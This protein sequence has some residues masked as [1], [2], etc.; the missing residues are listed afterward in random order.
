MNKTKSKVK[1]DAAVK[2]LVA[3][4]NKKVDERYKLPEF[5]LVKL[6]DYLQGLVDE[7][8]NGIVQF[9]I[10][11][12]CGAGG[13]SEG[14]EKSVFLS[15]KCSAII[16]GIN[17]DKKAIYSQAI[18]H[19]L[20]Y[21]T[22]EDIR[23]AHLEPI[24]NLL[25]ILRARFPQCPIILW[26]SLECTNHSNAKG[27]MSRDPDSR[28]LPWELYRY[29]EALNPDGIWI[30]NVKEFAEWGPMM[31]KVQ[32]LKGSKKV[33]LKNPIPEHLSDK[34]YEEKI[35]TGWICSCPLEKVTEGKGKNKK[36]VALIPAWRVIDELKG[37]YFMPWVDK[38]NSYGYHMDRRIL[39]AADYGVP[40][41]RKRLFIIFMRKG[42]PIQ[43]PHPTHSKNPKPGD[44]FDGLKK[45][46][47]VKECLDFEVEGRSVFEPGHVQSDKTWERIY[48]GLIKFI[49]GGKKNFEVQDT[50][51]IMKYMGNNQKTGINVGASINNPSNAITVQGRLA[52]VN[53]LLFDKHWIA[54]YNSSHNNTK[55]NAGQ[56]IDQ[57]SP[58]ITTISGSALMNA[59]FLDV[60]YGKG[61]PSSVETPSPTV[62][63]K[64]GLSIVDV[65]FM[66]NYQGQSTANSVDETSPTIMTKEKLALIGVKHF[67]YKAY[68]S[69][70]TNNSVEN[71]CDTITS[72]PK[73]QLI[74]VD[75]FIMSPHFDNPGSSLEQPAPT[76]VASRKH[77]YLLNMS[78]FGH[79]TS[80]NEPSVT[81]IAR[82]DKAPIYLVSV[83]ESAYSLAI[84]IFEDDSEIVIK[85]KEF[86]VRYNIVDI[87]KRML[88]I[89]EL[90]KIQSFPNDYYLA[91]SQTDQKKFIGNAVPPKMAKA[92]AESMYDALN[93]YLSKSLN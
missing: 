22:D 90:K 29:L 19:P 26:A 20:A 17:H 71:P 18:N 33:M 88:L 58:T 81:I 50:S 54:K 9:V 25:E 37:T 66:L 70:G 89:P 61:T 40:Q 28:A 6:L 21:Y 59:Q 46:I 92:I 51:F 82:Q 65:N 48:E 27:G 43:W 5:N 7:A 67:I 78:Y 23:F 91:G 86:M 45:Q 75:G 13:T 73:P 39:N 35:N 32:L 79:V 41:N 69:G 38:V 14:I 57:P 15:K 30:E 72:N 60:I 36:V 64:D 47:P 34:Y 63:T 74:Q 8:P 24:A 62:R 56:S 80:D 53:T 16:A 12:F 44:M 42:W 77:N 83:S 10:D 84:P 52:L 11:L 2:Q 93:L 3:D 87:K 68:T 85:I 76:Q 31:P 55:Q 1:I 49:A 4:A